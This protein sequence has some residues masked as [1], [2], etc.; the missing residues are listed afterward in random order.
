MQQLKPS[1]ISDLI[2]SKIQS[3]ALAADVRPQ[4]LVVSVTDCIC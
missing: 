2:R 4:V 3:M 1:E